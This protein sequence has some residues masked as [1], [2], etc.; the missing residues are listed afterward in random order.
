M[1]KSCFR[2]VPCNPGADPA[3]ISARAELELMNEAIEELKSL[4]EKDQPRKNDVSS[5]GAPELY[6]H[7]DWVAWMEAGPWPGDEEHT[8]DQEG[9]PSLDAIGGKGKG[10]GRGKDGKGGKGVGGK[11]WGGNGGKGHGKG[12]GWGDQSTT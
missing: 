5:M 6:S 7:E 11:A 3:L 12:K 10:K 8:Y 9:A 2:P 1:G 4:D